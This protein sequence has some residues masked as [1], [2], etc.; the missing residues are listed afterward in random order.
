[1]EPKYVK[2]LM[3]VSFLIWVFEMFSKYYINNELI[4][5]TSPV[6]IWLIAGFGWMILYFA[7]IKKTNR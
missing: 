3:I 7:L 2:N 1:M 4:K 5:I 6:H